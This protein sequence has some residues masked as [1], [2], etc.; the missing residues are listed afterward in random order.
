MQK[1]NSEEYYLTILCL[2]NSDFEYIYDSDFEGLFFA[3]CCRSSSSAAT[4]AFAAATAGS[5][6]PSD[7]PKGSR[8]YLTPGKIEYKKPWE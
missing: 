8:Q 4:T 2:F 1:T 5:T 7:H 3:C 6:N